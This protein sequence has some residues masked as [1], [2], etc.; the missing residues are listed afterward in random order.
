MEL[1][2]C[3]VAIFNIKDKNKTAKIYEQRE[4]IHKQ[5]CKY[6]FH[7][8]VKEKIE[9]VSVTPGTTVN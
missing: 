1:Q 8:K 6:P 4:R 7:S 5:T 3:F 9:I 2:I